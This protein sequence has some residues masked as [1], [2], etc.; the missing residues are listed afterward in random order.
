ML[1]VAAYSF[2]ACF[3]AACPKIPKHIRTCR[4]I[5]HL[6]FI[7]LATVAQKSLLSVVHMHKACILIKIQGRYA[8]LLANENCG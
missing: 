3:Q 2:I 6:L 4:N 8:A 7:P 1:A 5:Y